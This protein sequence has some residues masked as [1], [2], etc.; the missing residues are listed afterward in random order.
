MAMEDADYLGTLLD[1]FELE[2]LDTLL[3]FIRTSVHR[4]APEHAPGALSAPGANN[5]MVAWLQAIEANTRRTVAGPSVA[6]VQ[7]RAAEFA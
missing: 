6:S 4:A 5:D 1:M 3:A 2:E 7:A